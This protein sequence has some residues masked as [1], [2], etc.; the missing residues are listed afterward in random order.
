MKFGLEKVDYKGIYKGRSNSRIRWK[1]YHG[2]HLAILGS[3]KLSV[4]NDL[5]VRKGRFD[6]VGRSSMDCS[7]TSETH[8]GSAAEGLLCPSPDHALPCWAG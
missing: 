3:E 8:V 7:A 5:K 4:F 2:V 6:A 1:R